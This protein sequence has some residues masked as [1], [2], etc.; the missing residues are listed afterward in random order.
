MTTQPKG[1]SKNLLA[2]GIV[3]L[4]LG[5]FA[6]KT[7]L[8]TTVEAGTVGVRFSSASGVV[9]DD[10]EPGFHM[11]I[12]GLHK[13]QVLPSSYFFLNYEDEDQFTIRTKD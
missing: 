6:A 1:T 13:V 2:K 9:E 12:I 3:I 8:F 10:L 7:L 11:E 4:A 5:I